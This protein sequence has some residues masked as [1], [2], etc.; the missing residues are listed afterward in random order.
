[1]S[2]KRD[3]PTILNAL[4]EVGVWNSNVF[5]LAAPIALSSPNFAVPPNVGVNDFA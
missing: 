2:G 1:M 5:Y 3:D 4:S